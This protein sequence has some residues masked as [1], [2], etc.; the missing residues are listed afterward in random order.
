M[1]IYKNMQEIPDCMLG[2]KDYGNVMYIYKVEQKNV[3]ANKLNLNQTQTI[4]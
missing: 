3:Q 4:I 2:W 1:Y